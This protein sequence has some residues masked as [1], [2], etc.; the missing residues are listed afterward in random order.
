MARVRC[1]VREVT[2]ENDD[3]HE[4]DGVEVTCSRCDHATQSYGTG[5]NSVRRCLVLLREECPEG[6]ENFYVSEDD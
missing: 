2:V 1:T 3:G 5:E 6:E 4:V